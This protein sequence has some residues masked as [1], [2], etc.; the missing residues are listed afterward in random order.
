M[1]YG[2]RETAPAA[3]KIRYCQLSPAWNIAIGYFNGDGCGEPEA[4]GG[5]NDNA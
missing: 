1:T 5:V 2:V 3:I 4:I